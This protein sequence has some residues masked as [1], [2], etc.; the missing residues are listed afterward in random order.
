MMAGTDAALRAEAR[1]HFVADVRAE[2]GDGPALFESSVL[3][4]TGKKEPGE[5]QP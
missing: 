5:R 1:E 2:S 4:G 3:I